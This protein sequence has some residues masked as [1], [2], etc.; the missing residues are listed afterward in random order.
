MNY[1]AIK[2][3]F[4]DFYRSSFR[5]SK[6]EKLSLSGFAIFFPMIFECNVLF[7]SNLS[8]RNN[9]LFNNALISFEIDRISNIVIVI[10]SQSNNNGFV[11]DFE[12]L[13][14]ILGTKDGGFMSR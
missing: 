3:R 13:K 4:F 1:V 10:E 8:K 6:N 12:N 2:N 11:I 9:R 14:K 5:R 7:E